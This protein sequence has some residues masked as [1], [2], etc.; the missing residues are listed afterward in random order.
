METVLTSLATVLVTAVVTLTSVYLSHRWQSQEATNSRKGDLA[1]DLRATRI[2]FYAEYLEK[3][4]LFFSIL[5]V[6]APA[7]LN[8]TEGNSVL[9]AEALGPKAVEGLH[10]LN[11][12]SNA[13]ALLSDV[14]V[15]LAI[16]RV[17]YFLMV[18]LKKRAFEKDVSRLPSMSEV[19]QD[20]IEAMSAA[21]RVYDEADPPGRP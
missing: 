16:S 11:K 8:Q 10:N 12:A 17:E 18:C 15:R 3:A 4:R 20:L 9:L 1:R 21:V 6:T 13:V 7:G 14:P 2:Q 19:E 5:E